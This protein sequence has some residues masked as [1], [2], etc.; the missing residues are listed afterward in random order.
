MTVSL[1]STWLLCFPA[2]RCDGFS[3]VT[4]PRCGREVISSVGHLLG[5]PE[6]RGRALPAPGEK[7]T[8]LIPISERGPGCG[9]NAPA[10]GRRFYRPVLLFGFVPPLKADCW[11]P[12]EDATRGGTEAKAVGCVLICTP[13]V[14]GQATLLLS[15]RRISNY[16]PGGCPRSWAA[17]QRWLQH[18]GSHLGGDRDPARRL[19]NSPDNLP[20][21]PSTLTLD[22]HLMMAMR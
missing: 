2:V 3:G 12:G 6:V 9:G 21:L 18:R 14:P 11:Q 16:S 19:P 10:I 1:A 5:Y 13:G 15:C 22:P 8:P 4:T 17:R 7:M 20:R